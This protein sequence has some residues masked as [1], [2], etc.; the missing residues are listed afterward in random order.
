MWAPYK[1]GTGIAGVRVE[2]R[3]SGEVLVSP[4]SRNTPVFTRLKLSLLEVGLLPEGQVHGHELDIFQ[5]FP[6]PSFTI[7]LAASA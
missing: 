2:A 7:R 5:V 3:A 6:Q 4:R 1:E